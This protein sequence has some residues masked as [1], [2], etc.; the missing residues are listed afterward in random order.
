MVLIRSGTVTEQRRWHHVTCPDRNYKR[1]RQSKRSAPNHLSPINCSPHIRWLFVNDAFSIE[2]H[3]PNPLNAW[4]QTRCSTFDDDPR[5][6]K[7]RC[8]YHIPDRSTH[9]LLINQLIA[10]GLTDNLQDVAEILLK[11][12]CNRRWWYLPHGAAGE[13]WRDWYSKPTVSNAPD[14]RHC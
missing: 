1:D 8:T 13:N 5:R 14:N 2:A 3:E 6:G 10:A 9:W 4:A 11:T 7:K 12:S